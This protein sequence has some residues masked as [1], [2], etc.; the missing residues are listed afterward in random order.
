MLLDKNVNYILLIMS[1][2]HFI[3]RHKTKWLQ[4]H[5]SVIAETQKLSYM[6]I[7]AIIQRSGNIHPHRAEVWIEAQYVKIA[8]LCWTGYVSSNCLAP[9]T[10]TCQSTHPEKWDCFK[11]QGTEP[12]NPYIC[13][14]VP[15]WKEPQSPQRGIVELYFTAFFTSWPA[16]DVIRIKAIH[17]TFTELNFLRS[18]INYY[19]AYK[20]I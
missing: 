19:K 20:D 9:L 17:I 3:Y 11:Q 4:M 12:V 15:L 6:Y 5:P 8:V 14:T 10:K 7:S 18:A 1:L 2:L 16:Q 13:M